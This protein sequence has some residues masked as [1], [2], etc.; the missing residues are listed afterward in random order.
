[1]LY[2]AQSMYDDIEDK[3]VADLGCGWYLYNIISYFMH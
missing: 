2:T 3:V 1:M